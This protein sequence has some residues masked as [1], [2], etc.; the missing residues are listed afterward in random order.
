[1]A[2]GA[3]DAFIESW[4]I[5]GASSDSAVISPRLASRWTNPVI[6]PTTSVLA[7]T[8][9]RL[10]GPSF[11]LGRTSFV[12]K[13]MSHQAHWI[14]G[15]AAKV[16]ASGLVSAGGDL[17]GL[18]NNNI[19]MFRLQ[20][21]IDGTLTMYAGNGVTVIATTASP[22]V[23]NNAWFFWEVDVALTGTTN[24][25]V[26]ASLKVN[27]IVVATGAVATGIN[28]SV[29]LSNNATTNVFYLGSGMG[30]GS[31]TILL[32]GAFYIHNTGGAVPG[33]WGDI[34][35]LY[36]LPNGDTA[37]ADWAP[38]SGAVHYDRVNELPKDDDTTYLADGTA[39]QKDAWDWQNLA[40]LTGVV[41][42]VQLS[43][44]ARKDAEGAKS[45]RT[46]VGATLSEALSDTFYVNDSYIYYHFNWDLDPATGLAWTITNFNAKQFGIDVVA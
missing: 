14:A 41:R 30:S 21:N 45:F 38:N 39:A 10:N 32:D 33:Y 36:V 37:Q 44:A 5:Y 11:Q 12:Y 1:M 2:F 40:A 18:Q 15:C 42:T 3:Y 22:I 19:T 6:N 26:T 28:M 9:G 17:F 8:G 29:F 46:G 16:P 13:T 43:A 7:A 35:V 24:I 27:G 20:L 34:Q 23:F 31:S 25:T 4:A